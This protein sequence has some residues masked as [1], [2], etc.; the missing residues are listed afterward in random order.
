MNKVGI[1]NLLQ[2]VKNEELEVEAAIDII[3]L[4]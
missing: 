2:K 3:G 1:R 4:C